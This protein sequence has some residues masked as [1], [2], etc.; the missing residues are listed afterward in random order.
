MWMMYYLTANT[1]GSPRPVTGIA[2]LLYMWMMYVPH[3]K[4]LWVSTACYGDSF[5][6]AICMGIGSQGAVSTTLPKGYTALFSTCKTLETSCAI[7]CNGL[8]CVS[9][10]PRFS[11]ISVRER[12]RPD[13]W[14]GKCRSVSAVARTRARS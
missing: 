2:L 14:A 3:S 12:R 8:E 7:M 10:I 13:S 6:S 5:T 9:P 11:I 4:H 1:C